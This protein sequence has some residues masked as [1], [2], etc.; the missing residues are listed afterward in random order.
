MK[1]HD[2]IKIT[3]FDFAV[4]VV[5]FNRTNKFMLDVA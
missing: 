4:I 5:L 3:E 2:M 1:A